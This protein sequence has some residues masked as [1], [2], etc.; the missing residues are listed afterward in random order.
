MR[1]GTR[2]P[3]RSR[4]AEPSG[5]SSLTAASRVTANTSIATVQAREV[6]GL[7]ACTQSLTPASGLRPGGA[8]VL[9]TKKAIDSPGLVARADALTEVTFAIGEHRTGT[10]QIR[11]DAV[12]IGL[13]LRRDIAFHEVRVGRVV[14]S[15]ACQTGECAEDEVE[16]NSLPN[17]QGPEGSHAAK[18][19]PG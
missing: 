2:S 3:D 1:S 11:T 12:A 16:E 18:E 8:F 7:A 6:V 19:S 15:T 14:H 4:D 10:T 9:R 13:I 17:G 5:T